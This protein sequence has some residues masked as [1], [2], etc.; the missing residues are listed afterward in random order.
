MK[1]RL[2]VI[3]F[4]T[5]VSLS[6]CSSS[7]KGTVTIDGTIENAEQLAVQYPGSVSSDGKITLLL[8]V[9]PFGGE[10]PPIVLD[11]LI[12]PAKNKSFALRGQA[13]VNNMI[14]IV[15]KKGPVVPLVSDTSH[16]AVKLDFSGKEKFYDVQSSTASKQLQDFIFSYADKSE[17]VSNSMQKL[18]S[19]KQ[20]G[21]A[22]SITL[23]AT[24]KKNEAIGDLNGLLRTTLAEAGNPV[25]ASFA[26][27]RSA[28]TMQQSEFETE[29]TKLVKRFPDNADLAGLQKR[30]ESQKQ[31]AAERESRLKENSWVGKQAPAL[32]MPDVNGKE[33]SIASFKGKYVL[34]DFWASWCGPCRQENPNVVAAYNKF[35]DKNFTV[36]GVSLDQKKENWLQAIEQ[37][38]LTWTHISDLAYWKSKAV[39]TFGFEGIPFNVL[40][41]PKGTIIAEGLRG[42]ALV[43]K[44]Q[45]VLK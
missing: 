36:L 22:D 7:P 11:S 3:T 38:H 5:I 9:V 28:R 26:L 4:A 39:S 43:N 14:D 1:L 30:Y 27:G 45:E 24:N 17:A 44:L 12:I 18:D 29:L 10:T 19:L 15:I 31:M 23:D 6:A 8:Y 37:D 32:S 42:D 2:S 25:V 33:I 20:F 21:A 16:I 34:V 35:K 40:I 13:G 41:D